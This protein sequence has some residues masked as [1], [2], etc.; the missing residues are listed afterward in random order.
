M[1][2]IFAA[3]PKLIKAISQKMQI[4]TRNMIMF[5][6]QHQERSAGDRHSGRWQVSSQ[7]DILT[8]HDIG[9]LLF[10]GVRRNNHCRIPRPAVG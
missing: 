9:K 3:S 5:R 7:S 1:T 8:E 4:T 10:V 2:D 6:S